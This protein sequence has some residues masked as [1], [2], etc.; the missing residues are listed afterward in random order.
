VNAKSSKSVRLN[1][2]E[3]RVLQYVRRDGY[4]TTDPGHGIRVNNAA[5]SLVSK[6]VC[7]VIR[8]GEVWDETRTQVAGGYTEVR[9]TTFS[10]IRVA[11]RTVKSK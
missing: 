3:Q 2:S 8:R 5:Y 4:F 9:Q 11:F 6:K 10:T 1:K 7:E